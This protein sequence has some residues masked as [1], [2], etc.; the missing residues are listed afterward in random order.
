MT[1]R[2][3]LQTSDGQRLETRIDSAD[4]PTRFTV[5]CHPH[6]L[7]GG[8]MNAPLMIAIAGRLVDRGH[9]VLRFNFR[10]TGASTGTHDDGNGEVEDVEAA[11]AYARSQDLP[12]GLAG[13]SF[14]AGVALRWLATDDGPVP[15]VGVAPSAKSLPPE[16]P[17]GPKRM[18][19][20]TRD[21]LI[22]REPLIAYAEEQAIDLVLTPGDHFFHGRGKRIG[23][24]VGQG[25]EDG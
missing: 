21:Q 25:L 1:E 2:F 6:P 13:W 14:G 23:D 4:Q 10:G 3:E 18:I 9:R 5:L 15:Y 22:E 17:A 16:L 11:M 7:Q 24:L 20:G 8:S 19:L 12:V